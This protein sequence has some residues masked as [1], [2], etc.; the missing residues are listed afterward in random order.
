MTLYP[1]THWYDRKLTRNPPPITMT[2]VG[3]QLPFGIKL[4]SKNPKILLYIVICETN[5]PLANTMAAPMDG[6]IFRRL[7]F[8]SSISFSVVLTADDENFRVIPNNANI[9]TIATATLTIA[10]VA[11]VAAY[12]SNTYSWGISRTWGFDTG[13]TEA[14]SM[15]VNMKD[16]TP[17]KERRDN[18]AIP[19][20]PCPVVHPLPK[21]VPNPTRNPPSR[22][23]SDDAICMFEST[24]VR[25]SC[26]ASGTIQR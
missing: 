21:R 2:S 15:P 13:N 4:K 5:N 24:P 10:F 12:F 9:P 22:K 3:S 19:Q 7:F 25:P 18:R 16:M 14:N 20:M 8:H 11:V 17:T 23:P 1:S 6:M 26:N